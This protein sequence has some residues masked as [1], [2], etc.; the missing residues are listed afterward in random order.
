MRALAGTRFFEVSQ[1]KCMI[2]LGVDFAAEPTG[3]AIAAIDRDGSHLRLTLVNLREGVSEIVSNSPN[4]VIVGINRL[5]GRP[6][7]TVAFVSEHS[8]REVAL[9]ELAAIRP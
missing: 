1:R 7:G 9:R 8:K 3:T 2:T 6:G 5:L 4:A